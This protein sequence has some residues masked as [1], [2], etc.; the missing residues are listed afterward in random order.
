MITVDETTA[1][2][3]LADFAGVEIPD[4]YALR[5]GEHALAQAI[6]DQLEALR[7]EIRALV[8]DE[9]GRHPGA[10]N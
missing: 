5:R 9:L 2:A 7:R 10:L 1:R 4:D 6:A 3:L 8:R